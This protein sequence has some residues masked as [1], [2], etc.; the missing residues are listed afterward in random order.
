MKRLS[1]S[2]SGVTL[3][4][5][6][7]VIAILAIVIGL[8]LAAVQRARLVAARAQ[9]ANNLRQIALGLSNYHAALGRLPPGARVGYSE[10]QPYMSWLARLL[11]YVEQDAVW[12]QALAAYETTKDFTVSPPHPL[13]TVIPLYGCPADWRVQTAAVSRGKYLVAFTSYLGVAGT[14][15]F[16]RDGTLYPNSTECLTDIT[17]GTSMTILVGERPPSA[18]LWYGWW[19]A[20]TGTSGDRGIFADTLLGVREMAPLDDPWVPDCGGLPAHF[21]PGNFKNMCD[22]FHFWSLHP[23]GAN[24]LF[25]DGSVR[26]L[27]YAVDPF[28][29]AL[30]TR[31]GAEVALL[32]Y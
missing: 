1:S 23:G 22:A 21:A 28:L 11:P 4:E 5:T 2:R 13:S 20:G 18:D 19:Y 27:P 6:L 30:A 32:P 15:T 7:V 26:F 16:K 12:R 8:T 10:P 24:F 29:P 25:A 17:D 31:A 14:R 3:V 9:C